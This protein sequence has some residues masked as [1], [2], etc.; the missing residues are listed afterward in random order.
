MRSH[1]RR[2]SIIVVGGALA[3][4]SVGYGLGTQAGD[5]N[6]IADSATQ[7]GGSQ[8]RHLGPGPAFERGAPPGFSALAT[9]LGVDADKLAQAMRDF[10]ES[11]EADRRDEFTN[12]LAKALGIS[13]DKVKSAL[14]GLNQRREDRFAGRLA[15]ALG[16][17]ADKVQSALE[18]LKDN[19]P[20]RFGDFA[21]KLADELNLD[22]SDVRAALMKVRPFHEERRG[23]RHRDD[24]APLRQLATALGVSRAELRAAFRQ[25]QRGR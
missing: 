19:G 6:A 5:G 15:D 20:V 23:G 8:E 12:K 25:L 2:T 22:V 9:K 17:D 21:Q 13:S 14:D 10:H 11:Q 3:I 1:R 24:A 7:D 16:V 18:K 4:A